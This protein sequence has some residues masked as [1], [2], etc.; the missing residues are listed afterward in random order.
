MISGGGRRRILSLALRRQVAPI[1]ALLPQGLE[2]RPVQCPITQAYASF[3][4]PTATGQPIRLAISSLES[5]RLTASP[6]LML[7]A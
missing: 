1:L 6:H 3:P 2:V 5:P 7:W 4:Q